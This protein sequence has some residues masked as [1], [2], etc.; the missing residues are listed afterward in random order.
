MAP[1]CGVT[2]GDRGRTSRLSSARDCPDETDNQERLGLPLYLAL[3]EAMNL[4]KAELSEGLE[5][6]AFRPRV[7]SDFMGGMKSGASE[8]ALLVAVIHSID[9]KG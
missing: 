1:A 8:R 7:R 2:A 3:A 5:T 6:R 9:M 4:P